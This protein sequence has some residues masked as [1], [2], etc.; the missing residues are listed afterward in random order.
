MCAGVTTYNALR[1]SGARPGDVVAIL[2][3]GGL[4]HLAVQYAAKMGY[5]TVAIA[6]GKDKENFRE[7]LGAARYINNQAQDTVAELGK[8]GGAKIIAATVTSGKA[9]SAVVPGLSLNGKLLVVGAPADPVEAASVVL[10]FGRRSIVGAYSGTAID[11]QDTLAFSVLT[12]V[13]SMNE[14]FPVRAG[15]EGVRADDER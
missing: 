6:R 5:R 3:V 10:I 7:E 14:V 1:D 4:G 2:G 13:R 9:M 12:N 8:L 11:S 15:A